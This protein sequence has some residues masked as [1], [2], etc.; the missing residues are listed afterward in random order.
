MRYLKTI[1]LFISVALCCVMSGCTDKIAPLNGEVVQMTY[2]QTFLSN[3]EAY[4]SELFYVNNLTVKIADPTIIY[5]TEGKDAGWY[6]AYGTSD[7]I[8]CRG[9]QGWRSKNLSDW[10][11]VGIVL[12]PD[13]ENGWADR[14]FW[15]PEVIYDEEEK[16]YYM[17]YTATNNNNS[18]SLAISMA[19]SETPDGPFI[20]P[21]GFENADGK[22][23]NVSKPVYDFTLSNPI[24]AEFFKNNPSFEADCVLDP[25]AFIDPVS[26]E[27]YLYFSYNYSPTCLCSICGVKMKD[28]FTP[29][30]STLTRLTA[31]NYLTVKGAE[32]G[33]E[34]QYREELDVNEGA[35][36][37]YHNGRYY[38]TMSIYQYDLPQYK[39][40]QA[41]GDNPLG[42]FE[43]LEYEDGGI[44]ICTGEDWNHIVSSGHHSF[45]KC[46][47]ELMIAYH[48]F[49]NRKDI[50]SGRA[51]AVDKVVWT[52]NSDGVE[53]MHTNGPTW[54]VQPLPQTISG[55]TNIAPE[56]EILADNTSFGDNKGLITDGLV[57]LKEDDL[58]E[59]YNL[60][61]GKSVI[62]LKWDDYRTIRGLL[63]YN[64]YDYSRAFEKVEKIEFEC[65]SYISTI[66]NIKFDSKWNIED[67]G[68]FIRPASTAESEFDEISAKSVTITFEAEKEMS[69]GEI[70]I[71]GK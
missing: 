7:L 40:V 21:D 10:E 16:L 67:E 53:V 57:K 11:L 17:F 38:L 26:G 46:G 1:C 2:E 32:K 33:T 29:D 9:I 70:I 52:E 31:P 15:A 64:S 49:M 19:Y 28:W 65:D 37:L 59:E 51:L 27:K 55:Y 66:E 22:Q 4:N 61:S 54:S 3:D 35:F 41:I 18:G 12:R 63:I 23:L 48:T 36:M 13:F 20:H 8:G 69:I 34:R 5:I 50:H 39:V 30:Y 6:Y 45:F 68:E 43:K 42:N 60:K 14:N 56:A 58:A 62:R 47:D 25:C 44:V 24:I 71:L